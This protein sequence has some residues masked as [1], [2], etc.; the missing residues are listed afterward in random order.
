MATVMTNW[1]DAVNATGATDPIDVSGS[2]SYTL[3]ATA[4]G[5]PETA[6]VSLEGSLDGVGYTIL[7]LLSG[8]SGDVQVSWAQNKPTK[9]MRLNVR[10]ITG[11]TSPTITAS[12]IAA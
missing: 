10:A 8:L 7:V 6:E 1:L 3:Q 9:Y 11:G 5:A 4:T 12:A 2:L